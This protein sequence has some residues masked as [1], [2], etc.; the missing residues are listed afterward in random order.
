[1]INLHNGKF[2]AIQ[3]NKKMY[4]YGTFSSIRYEMKIARN[5]TLKRVLSFCKKRE[6]I[7]NGNA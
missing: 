4:G 6:K 3:K 1:M 7:R 2:P 5:I